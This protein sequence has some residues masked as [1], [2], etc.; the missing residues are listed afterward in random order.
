MYV[1]VEP[2][3]N[4]LNNSSPLVILVRVGHRA[5]YMR[6]II[7]II[8]ATRIYMYVTGNVIPV[9]LVG[10]VLVSKVGSSGAVYNYY[11]TYTSR[12]EHLFQ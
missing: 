4:P 7:M 9:G 2:G 10:G 3:V 1:A 8:Y 12:L 6:I 5:E 11:I